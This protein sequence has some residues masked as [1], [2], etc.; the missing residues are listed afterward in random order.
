MGESYIMGDKFTIVENKQF[1]FKHISPIPSEEELRKYYESQYYN[2][3]IKE[4][5]TRE[6]KLLFDNNS[7]ND[8]LIWLENT[9]FKDIDDTLKSL[10]N[11]SSI[12]LI[13]IGCGSGEFI[14]YMLKKGYD[15]LGIE[16]SIDAYE[17][18]RAKVL[19]VEKCQFEDYVE[20]N[21]VNG[22]FDVINMTSVLEH[23]KDP[24]K[25]IEFCKKIIKKDGILRLEFAN[26]FN[27]FQQVVHKKFK[28]NEWWISV[29][30]HIYYF[31]L[32]SVK[33]MFEYFNF[34]II[35]HTADFP[36]EMFLL[37]GFNYLGDKSIG[38]QCHEARINFERS[39]PDEIRRDF[40]KSLSKIGIGR[41]QIVYARLK[42]SM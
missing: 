9:Y 31:N 2:K 10:I 26:D 27:V 16:P 41:K 42:E 40:Y 18:A 34:E 11:K 12:K 29:P 3:M 39:L 22:E 30:D 21:N 6:A 25:I 33:K 28:L 35:E 17:Q 7:R 20:K 32:K 15:V 14:S 24:I 36:M 1:G 5:N 37:M 23:C 19:N 38:K 4:N 13:D 8:E